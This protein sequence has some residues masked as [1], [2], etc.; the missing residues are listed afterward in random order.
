MKSP[1]S[2]SR[3]SIVD[4]SSWSARC[5]YWAGEL[6]KPARNRTSP[7]REHLP[8]VINGHGSRLFVN[9]GALVV[10]EGFTHYPQKRKEWRFFPRDSNL[11]SRIISV[12]GSGGLSFDA[13]D[14]LASQSVPLIRLDW[15]GNVQASI[16]HIGYAA[17]AKRVAAQIATKKRQ[18]GIEIA[19]RLIDTKIRNSIRTISSAFPA[20]KALAINR[21]LSETR[22]KLQNAR[23]INSI[24]GIEGNAAATY[25]EGWHLLQLKW[26]GTGRRP[27]PHNWHHVGPRTSI[28]R[29][30]IKNRNASHPV[31][32]MLNY[33]YGVLQSQ[34]RIQIAISGYDPNISYLHSR[35]ISRQ[36]LVFDLM[37]PLRPIA[38]RVVLGIIRSETFHPTDFQLRRDGVCRLNPRLAAHLVQLVFKNI[39][40]NA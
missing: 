35:K 7:R 34:V 16:G 15:R 38:D 18:G 14:W 21:R 12:D 17:D 6:F 20:S 4:E 5:E 24:I 30:D 9:N 25:F 11:P 40:P 23:S 8:L 10:Q 3:A 37:E 22:Q 13:L 26:K 28:A 19:K 36:G 29:E 31:N 2:R 39:Y 1:S 27:I 33:A 32:A